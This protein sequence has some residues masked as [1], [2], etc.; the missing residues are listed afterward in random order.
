MVKVNNL[1]TSSIRNKFIAIV[2]LI[3]MIV[4]LI[5]GGYGTWVTVTVLREQVT[6]E[7]IARLRNFASGITNFLTNLEEDVVFLSQSQTLFQYLESNKADLTTSEERRKNLEQ[8]FLAFA[9]ARKIYD[10]IRFLDTTGQEI[11]RI[12]TNFDGVSTVVPQEELQNKADRYYFKDTISLQPGEIFVS[13][14]DLNVEQG[15]IEILPDGSNKPVLRY[16]TPVVVNGETVGVIVTN[17]LAKNFLDPLKEADE[18]IFLVDQDGYY[19][20]HPDESKR[21]GK[22]LGTNI[23][24]QSD[25]SQNIT[26]RLLSGN[27]ETLIEGGNF[28]AY[29][30]V[31]SEGNKT[32]WYLGVV[33]PQSELFAPAVSSIFVTLAVI[34]ATLSLGIVFAVS[35]GRLVTNPIIELQQAALRVA[36]GDFSTKF[37]QTSQDEIGSLTNSFHTMTTKLHEVVSSLEEQVADRTKELV[38][39]TEIGRQASSIRD[40]DELLS[41]ITEFIRERFNLYYTHIYFVDDLSQHLV[42]KSGTGAVGQELLARQHTLPIGPGSIVGQVAESGQSIVVSDIGKSDL[43]KPNPLLPDTRSE[44]AVPLIVEGQVIGV[45]DMQSDR[46]NTFAENNLAAL[47]AMAVQLAISINS[48]KQWAASQEAQRQAEAAL[49]RLTGETWA[50]TL[51][52]HQKD[53]AFAYDLSVVT[54]LKSETQ[55]GNGYESV[56]VVVQNTA[57]GH[58]SVKKAENREL[59]PDE[60]TLMAAVAQQ[61]AQK[62]ENLRLFEQTQQRAAREQV[63]RQITDK[64]RSSKDIETAL[65]T[66]AVELSKALG[67]ARAMVDIQVQRPSDNSNNNK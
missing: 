3:V 28:F 33:R 55:N 63:A 42:M 50:E 51:T 34:V 38:L 61:L 43:H 19:L 57:I 66:A 62:A 4:T 35:V 2:I 31:V 60:Q 20:S 44:V 56:P 32:T 26:Q 45:L 59:T 58:L 15:E 14:L 49:Q 22:D 12:N 13:P 11:V 9:K 24:L 47:E 21:W 5:A 1:I 52:G 39:T 6:K 67:T 65:K 18:T 46:A 17:V 16:G 40:L 48:A 54:S 41:S 30:P 7:E 53:T 10:Q 23:T 29:Q 25:Y 37:T 27:T 8:E 64:I 36:E